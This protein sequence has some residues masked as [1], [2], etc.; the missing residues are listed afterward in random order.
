[1]RDFHLA[2]GASMR[3]GAN[4]RD[5]PAVE[6]ASVHDARASMRPGAKRRD[7]PGNGQRIDARKAARLQ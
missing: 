3:P 5:H 6:L 2:S 4:R 7:H 1:M